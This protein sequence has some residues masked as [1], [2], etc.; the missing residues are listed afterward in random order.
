MNFVFETS[1]TS[2]LT[3]IVGLPRRLDPHGYILRN[4]EEMGRIVRTLKELRE[5]YEEIRSLFFSSSIEQMRKSQRILS[6]RQ[7]STC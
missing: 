1:I 7:N 5:N 2:R 3:Q 6:S 4:N